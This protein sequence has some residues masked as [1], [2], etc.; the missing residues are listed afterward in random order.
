MSI[1]NSRVRVGGIKRRLNRVILSTLCIVGIFPLFGQEGDKKEAKRFAPSPSLARWG[2]VPAW[3]GTFQHDLHVEQTYANGGT[4]TDDRSVAGTVFLDTLTNLGLP[5]NAGGDSRNSIW[6]GIAKASVRIH[7][8]KIER[9]TRGQVR[10]RNET[11]GEDVAEADC[12]LQIDATR[13]TF[14]LYVRQLR[15]DVRQTYWY[16]WSSPPKSTSEVSTG[17]V[18][19]TS[20]GGL[21]S[22]TL[23]AA[24]LLL[25]QTKTWHPRATQDYPPRVYTATYSYTL[26]PAGKK[27]E[28]ELVV[29][30]QGYD[31]WLPESARS[32][33]IAGNEI[34]I[35]AEL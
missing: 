34:R 5:N 27:P 9:D 8:L 24:G 18:E 32:E 23:P 1:G 6:H 17:V 12:D 7:L 29:K 3:E 14:I 2:E 4:N 30:P 16:G 35:D 28:V 11:I 33:S 20:D 10:S 26:H 21:G 19:L 25:T 22:G 13:G 15:I 31:I